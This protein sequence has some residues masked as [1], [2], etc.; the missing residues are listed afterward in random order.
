MSEQ[1]SRISSLQ[2][3]LDEQRH[4]AEELHRQG[5]SDLNVRVY[6]LQSQLNNVQEKLTAREK[7]IVTLK[8]HL[9]QSK[10][11]IDRLEAELALGPDGDQNKLNKLE[12][13]LNVKDKEN[14]KLKDK[15][16]NEMI[17][18]LALPDL[19][20]TMLADKNE[21]IDY[22][23]EQLDAKTAA[24][25]VYLDLNLDEQQLCE[26]KRKAIEI[27]D[28]KSSARTLSD[29]VSLSEYDEPDIIRK[30]ADSR[31]LQTSS[32]FFTIPSLAKNDDNNS[33]K[34]INEPLMNYETPS[35]QP[36]KIL[37][38]TQTTNDDNRISTNERKFLAES[39]SLPT[40]VDEQYMLNASSP[41][42]NNLHEK[43]AKLQNENMEKTEE[44]T[45]LKV[46]LAEH[47]EMHLD[48]AAKSK[49]LS[50][51]M[52][53]K[54]ELQF[55][56]DEQKSQLTKLINTS[57]ATAAAGVAGEL[58]SNEQK[59]ENLKEIQQQFTEKCQQFEQLSAK[60]E[61]ILNE[62]ITLKTEIDLL[63]QQ[64][65]SL[66][67]TINHKDELLSK[68]EKN[69]INYAQTESR[70]LETINRLEQDIIDLNQNL[71]R[72]HDATVQLTTLRE[73]LD[74]T[75]N[76]LFDKMIDYEKCQLYLK[77]QA[78]TIEDL[79]D[80]LSDSKS[81]RSVEDMRIQIRQEQEKNQK[82]CDEIMQLRAI[83][84]RHDNNDSPKPYGLDEIARRVEKELNY[85][86]Q[87]DSNIIKAIES[88][89]EQQQHDSDEE[90]LQNIRQAANMAAELT[91][92]KEKYEIEK[93]NCLR[94]QRLLDAEKSNSTSLQEQDVNVIRAINLRLEASIS[95]EAE[96]Q[97]LL[98]IERSKCERLTTQLLVHQRTM[99]RD[100]S[101]HMKSSPQESPRRTPRTSDF[102]TELS[103][104]LQSEIKLL[105]AQ[106]ERERERVSDMERVIEREKC[107]YEKELTDRKEYGER[108]KREMDRI[109]KE[110]ETCEQELE[111]TQERLLLSTREIDS[112][113][114][115]IA[116]FQEIESRRLARRGQER[117]ESTHHLVEI[118]ELKLRLNYVEKERDNLQEKLLQLRGDIERSSQRE[119]QLTTALAAKDQHQLN[120]D[121]FVPK[122][123]LHQLNN[124]NSLIV[125]NTKDNRQMTETLQFLTT[126]RQTLQQ[127][128]VDLEMKNRAFNREE[129]EERANHLF[130]K[131]L[132]VES[133]RKALVHQKK[134]LLI[135][136]QTYQDNEAKALAMINGN[137]MPK[138]KI[139]SFRYELFFL[140]ITNFIKQKLLFL[141]LD[142]LFL[143][144]LPL[145]E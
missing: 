71:D 98:E 39:L 62:N 108:M 53:E 30:V 46:K 26:L 32:K 48:L 135:V 80:I 15:I 22:I 10:I 60:L 79:K 136:L 70:H 36:R 5:T 19:M 6:D 78:K 143:L 54:K 84:E 29:I 117:I 27:A 65:Q 33:I 129:L 58:N 28:G 40:I 94:L 45:K 103:N 73:E 1:I 141:V 16:R 8:D 35:P 2:S 25:Q 20:E 122:Q 14:Q 109:I 96:L 128:V 119:A 85:S 67:K 131:Y 95:Q 59:T 43:I 61:Q 134:Y 4:R 75:K 118:Q 64:V 72:N 124:M 106:N 114:A 41:L 145:N 82:F 123:F 132:R 17:N 52:V 120:N 81:P 127:R 142:R 57:N 139:K 49:L 130:G 66:D 56:F 31:D 112:L 138:K 90:K 137:A 63:T 51:L 3:R 24:L 47:S 9:E 126:E 89:H 50:D 12:A 111:H 140:K 34:S 77:Q 13:E 68:F 144:L 38:T 69:A 116:N 110:K 105:T 101:L 87:L 76:E 100:S 42:A 23:K 11:I 55:E 121:N 7:Q 86:A 113:E 91:T 21:E 133:Y 102:E 37:F 83:I 97:K 107:R 99:S 125:G 115:R 93:Q 44:L 92:V 74:R 18:K 104:R 88:E